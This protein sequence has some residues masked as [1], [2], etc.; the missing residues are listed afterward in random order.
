MS[1]VGDDSATRCAQLTTDNKNNNNKN[2]VIVTVTA[3][4]TIIANA[5]M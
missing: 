4:L 3:K 1:F 2:V 5:N